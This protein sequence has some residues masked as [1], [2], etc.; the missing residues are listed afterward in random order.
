MRMEIKTAEYWANEHKKWRNSGQDQ[1]SYCKKEGLIFRQFKS[2]VKK[3]SAAGLL[4]KKNAP[5]EKG[6]GFKQINIDLSSVGKEEGR[7]AYCDIWFQGKLGIRI[8]TEESLGH[9]GTLIKGLIR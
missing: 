7:P 3:A 9:L 1:E 6:D 4:D 8:E 5:T 2:G